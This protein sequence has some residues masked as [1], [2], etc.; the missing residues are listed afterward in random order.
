MTIVTKGPAPGTGA[1]V[2]YSTAAS[3]VRHHLDGVPEEELFS[4]NLNGRDVKARKGETIMEV[5]HRE[6]VYVPHYCWHPSLSIAGNC[7]LCLVE[8]EKVPKPVIGCQTHVTPGMVV[9]TQSEQAKDAQRWMMEF[10]LVNHPLDCPV[11]DRGGECQLQRYSME[12][13]RGHSRMADKKRKFVKPQADPLIDIERNRCIMCTRCVR[14]SDEIGGEHVM[15]VFDRGAGNYIGTFGQGPVSNIFSGNVIDL[16]PVGCLTNRPNRFRA[17]PWE[18]KQTQSTCDLCSAGCKVAHW[19][20]NDKH[21]RTTPPSRLALDRYTINEDTEEFICNQ[22]RFGSD[23]GQHASR[24]SESMMIKADRLVP[25]S[26]AEAIKDAAARLREVASQHGP[27]SIAVLVSPRA[28]L[29]EGLL[30]RDLA[31]NV[32]GT[33]SLDWRAGCAT[34]EA[35]NAVSLALR[36]ADGDLE[37]DHDVVV[38]LGGKLVWQEP[39]LALRLQ[40]LARRFQKKIVMIGQHNDDYLVKH[41]AMTLYPR[42]GAMAPALAVLMDAVRGGAIAPVAEAFGIDEAKALELTELLKSAGRGLVVHG[43]DELN[44]RRA[45]VEVPAAARFSRELG[46]TW[47]YLPAIRDRNAVGLNALGVEP[48]AG[49]VAAPALPDALQSGRI[50][51]LVVFGGDALAAL[52]DQVT[53]LEGLAAAEAVIL[54]D[55]FKSEYTDH[56]DVF[57]SLATNLERSGTYADI[58]GNLAV[59]KAAVASP[60]NARPWTQTLTALG[61]ALGSEDFG[62]DSLAELFRLVRAELAPESTCEWAELEIAGS[63]NEA[64][65][66][67]IR[68]KGGARNRSTEDNPGNYRKDGLHLRGSRAVALPESG[69]DVPTVSPSGT[70][71][72]VLLWGPHVSGKGYLTDRGSQADV[73]LPKP[74]AHMNPDDASRLNARDGQFAILSVGGE[75]A[76]AG[77]RLSAGVAPGTLYLPAGTYGPFDAASVG[78]PARVSVELLDEMVPDQGEALTEVEVPGETSKETN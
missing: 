29:E 27:E 10:L 7:R 41:A 25:T 36:A 21:Y 58:E 52:K 64:H 15:G 28:T 46:E 77:L 63:T 68:R 56:A 19:T 67:D 40:E 23:Y 66:V 45:A 50:K 78:L 37:A 17:R 12:Y 22:G 61:R 38:V 51:A 74:F 57:L 70:K 35:A 30:A 18:L 62:A 11:C 2:G 71:G 33:S 4:I 32:I 49:G 31:R 48:A 54:A 69:A 60:G 59:L 42:D 44:G 47:S 5:C 26:A 1:T 24:Q 9:R 16:C 8:V 3:R 73:L 53:L 20:R 34:T 55:H 43:L 75:K 39:V 6:D 13:G 14:F 65:Y 76:K 72:F